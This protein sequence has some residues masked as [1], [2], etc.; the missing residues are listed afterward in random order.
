MGHSSRKGAALHCLY[1]VE[2]PPVCISLFGVCGSG[3]WCI[4]LKDRKTILPISPKEFI[5]LLWRL[6][7]WGIHPYQTLTLITLIILI[8]LNSYGDIE[9]QTSLGRFLGSILM[10]LGYVS[11]GVILAHICPTYSTGRLHSN[12]PK[13]NAQVWDN[14]SSLKRGLLFWSQL[15]IKIPSTFAGQAQATC[16]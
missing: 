14:C 8:T 10:M 13:W 5:G 15:H 1:Y 16:L 7:L 12:H 3:R 6:Q 4:W 11:L 9:P 2:K